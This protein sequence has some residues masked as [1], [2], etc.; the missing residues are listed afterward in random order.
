MN[1][2]KSFK[3]PLI[4][5]LSQNYEEG[6]IFSIYIFLIFLLETKASNQIHSLSKESVNQPMIKNSPIMSVLNNFQEFEN[7]DDIRSKNHI[8]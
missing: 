2:S 6:Y 8:Y 1:K 4:R 3:E 5:S 7:E